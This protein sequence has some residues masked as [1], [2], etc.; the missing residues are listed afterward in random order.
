MTAAYKPRAGSAAVVFAVFSTLTMGVML[1]L[2]LQP[3]FVLGKD[4]IAQIDTGPLLGIADWLIGGQI[5]KVVGVIFVIAAIKFSKKRKFVSAQLIICGA[6]LLLNP[7][8]LI[9]ALGEI[10]GFLM[11]G[12]IQFVQVSPMLAQHSLIPSNSKWIGELKQYRAIAYLSEAVACFVKYPPYANGDIN[13]LMTDLSTFSISASQWNWINF[14]WA[15]AVMMCVELTFKFLLKAGVHSGA[16]S[17][18]APEK[19][20]TQ[21][22]SKAYKAYKA[23]KVYR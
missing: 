3:W 13:R 9:R 1:L 22:N 6:I 7:G 2:N 12:W 23:Y 15:I 20:A 5:A 17:K 11:W 21:Q 8:T 19:S 18:K 14:F 10:V 16:F 4:V